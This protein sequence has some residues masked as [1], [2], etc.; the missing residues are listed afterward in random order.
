M[1]PPLSID[2]FARP[3]LIVARELIGIR[4][5]RILPD[6]SRLVGRIVETEAY[7]QDDPATHGW[8]EGKG[9]L[10]I[11]RSAGLFTR[12]GTGYVYFT[13]GSHW[14]LN[15]TTDQ[16]G[17]AG[18]VLIRAVQPLEG[19]ELMYSN[20]PKARKDRGLASGPGKLAAAF[21]ITGSEFHGKDLTIPP[22]YF[23]QPSA[24]DPPLKIATSS[25][26]GLT[27]GVETQWRFYAK[28][29]PFVSPG[30]PSDILHA[31]KNRSS[32]Q[33]I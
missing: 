23:S 17:E 8:R 19:L 27:R 25:R 9:V 11:G 2:F 5:I 32:D 20:R 16:E 31:R 1:L 6:G 13:Y 28:D 14:M 33:N 15:V 21:G 22:L 12:P 24:D 30:V 18:A 4:L 3:T 26:I 29:H 7:M 10:P